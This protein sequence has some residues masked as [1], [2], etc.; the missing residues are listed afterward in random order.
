MPSRLG[1]QCVPCRDCRVKPGNDE[2]LMTCRKYGDLQAGLSAGA[3]SWPGLSSRSTDRPRIKIETDGA[4]AAAHGV[5]AVR[6]A[7]LL[8]HPVSQLAIALDGEH[9][10][11]AEHAVGRTGK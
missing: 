2:K 11:C 7:D 4:G 1:G 3:C 9:A 6:V 10:L 8:Q 5:L